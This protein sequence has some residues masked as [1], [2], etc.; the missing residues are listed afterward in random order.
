MWN[1]PI[2]G[3]GLGVQARPESPMTSLR[4]RI[5][6]VFALFVILGS[7]SLLWVFE[8]RQ[9][10]EEREAFAE[11]ARMNVAYMERT[12]IPRTEVM[13]GRLSEV[14]GA[15]V[16]FRDPKSGLLMGPEGSDLPQQASSLQAGGE[17]H[18][19]PDGRMLVAIRDGGGVETIFI[20]DP[21]FV[22]LGD[23]GA[24]AWLAIGLFW[25]LSIALGFGL[26]R[27]LSNPLG[28]LVEALPKVGSEDSLPALPKHRRDEIGS[29]ARALEETHVS[30]KEERDRRRQAERLAL[31]G[32]MATGMAHEIRNPAAA[33]RLH[34]ELM[35]ASAPDDL[36]KSRAVILDESERLENLVGQW[37][38][39][40][41][42]EPPKRSQLDLGELLRQVISTMEPQA[43]H[44]G[45]EIEYAVDADMKMQVAADRHRM[46]QVFS[47]L[48]LNGI[49]AMPTGGKLSVD[50]ELDG[51]WLVIR[52]EDEGK[53]FSE[54]ALDRAG[55]AF[56]S[57][58]EGGLGLGLAVATD[59][60]E[61]HRGK[62]TVSNL[63]GGGGAC[64]RVELPLGSPHDGK[65][66]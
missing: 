54:A 65:V 66:E 8:S 7:V 56:F 63:E 3:N 38:Y 25:A 61:A 52:I 36:A 35:D 45:V 9:Q 12:R 32:R 31:L 6:L 28:S 1:E 57:E 40:S 41:R 27:W 13:A 18:H 34:A 33:I 24:D 20:R 53:G 16:Y 15:E 44:A 58:R 17:V 50:G 10:S 37:M 19:L 59:I 42:P 55:E 47:N 48:L 21:Q 14:I 5:P 30:L 2:H 4:I 29:L 49:Q 46:Q 62:L 23:L 22:G 60:C 64:I 26:S 51:E 11:L 43:N 39:Y